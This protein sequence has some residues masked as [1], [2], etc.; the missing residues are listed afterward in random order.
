MAELH[1]RAASV[2]LRESRRG[3]K[4]T[5]TMKLRRFN[6]YFAQ[7]DL[8]RRGRGAAAG[9]RWRP[10]ARPWWTG[11]HPPEWPTHRRS[12]GAA[13]L[14]QQAPL[15]RF[16]LEVDEAEAEP[17]A[18][19]NRVSPVRSPGDGWRVPVCDHAV[20][21]SAASPGRHPDAGAAVD[22][23]QRADNEAGATTS[24]GCQRAGDAAAAA[25]VVVRGITSSTTFCQC[26][27][28]IDESG[29]AHS[30]GISVCW[31]VWSLL[32]GALLTSG[33]L[34]ARAVDRAGP[35]SCA[36]A[37]QLA[38]RAA[39]SRAAPG[40]AADHAVAQ[41]AAAAPLSFIPGVSSIPFH[42][43][44]PF[45]S[46][47]IFPGLHPFHSIP[48]PFHSRLTR[49]IPLQD[50]DTPARQPG[51]RSA[52]LNQRVCRFSATRHRVHYSPA[53]FRSSA[54]AARLSAVGDRQPRAS[55][56]DV[57]RRSKRH[58][59]K[60]RRSRI[61]SRARR[62]ATVE[63]RHRRVVG[64]GTYHSSMSIRRLYPPGPGQRKAGQ[65]GLLV[66]GQGNAPAA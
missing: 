10:G 43:V 18:R 35:R 49:S 44:D 60:P 31:A 1:R 57:C 34:P 19:A 37:A 51:S 29:G 20:P 27:G 65:V 59:H 21:A 64:D 5:A 42:P 62:A 52:P 3:G 32:F 22:H 25:A 39:A 14:P 28:G 46:F 8:C 58:R 23:E 15:R 50:G 30:G 6:Y 55:R 36:V 26:I 61:T 56:C 24:T 12:P 2:P 54:I 38:F 45:H 4:I 47:L 16:H 41:R 53:L 66:P 48:D 63:R 7:R 11:C 13:Q 17:R 33:R 9:P 40:S